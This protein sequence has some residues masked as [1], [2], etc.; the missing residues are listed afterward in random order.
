M[1]KKLLNALIAVLLLMPNFNFAQAPNLG[2]A[3]GFA[4][5]TATGAFNVTG[6]TTN[7]TGDV[8]TKVGAFSGFPPGILI[9]QIHVADAVSAQAATDVALAYGSLSPVTCGQVIPV[10]IGGVQ[11]LLPDVYC[12][13]AATVINGDLILDG[14]G[15]A[16]SLFIFKF[17]GALATTVNSRIILTNGASACNVYFQVNG[18]VDLGQNSIFQGT[19]LANG[20]I[21][22]LDGASLLGRGLSQAGA[23]SLQNNIVTLVAQPVA[24]VIIASGPTTFCAGDSVILSGNVGGMWSNGDTTFSITVTTSGNFFVTN[25]TNCG[26]ASSNQILVT[27][28]PSPSCTITGKCVICPGASTQLCAPSGTGRTYLWSTGATSRCITVSTAGT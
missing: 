10:T 22:L 18:Q 4:L 16:T 28:T 27:V 26:S 21:N 5:F 9:G 24:S 2:F 19:I 15:D 3:S 14:Q 12:T 8:G 25:T 6:S 13:G 17:N 11:T 7:V 1:I 20:A 23:I